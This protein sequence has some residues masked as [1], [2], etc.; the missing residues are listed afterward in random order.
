M[1]SRS[2]RE[3]RERRRTSAADWA[4]QQASGGFD[5]TDV[6][7]PEGMENYKFEE[8]MQ[9]FDV[10][11]FLAGKQ[12]RRADEGFE[13]FEVEFDIHK[14]PRPDGKESWFCCLWECRKEPCPAC[15]IRNNRDTAK[16]LSDQL[17]L[18]RRHLFIVNDKPG[19]SKNKLKLLNAVR[20]NRKLGFGEQ[21][22][23]AVGAS[24]GNK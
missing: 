21:L 24:R 7:I 19:D 16:E 13:H 9:A 4:Q 11:P 18:Q 1:A 10:M 2:E 6:R 15:K 17:R 22:I 23:V 5:A 8:G 12:N 14:I 3:S 20:W